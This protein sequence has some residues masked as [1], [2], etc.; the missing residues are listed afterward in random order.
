MADPAAPDGVTRRRA[1]RERALGLLY[2]AHTKREDVRELIAAL[3]L[4]PDRFAVELCEGVADH[5][6]ELDAT[7][8]E[9][10]TAWTPERMPVIDRIV[11]RLGAHELLHRPDIPTGVVLSEW[12]ELASEYSTADSSRFVNGVLSRLA[13]DGRP[14]SPDSE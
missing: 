8:R 5:E 13:R 11:L 12:V 2:E 14:P 3:P 6:A 7:L 9:L 4:R 1:A 10:S